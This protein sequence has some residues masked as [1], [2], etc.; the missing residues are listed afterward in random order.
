MPGSENST[1]SPEKVKLLSN[2]QKLINKTRNI[3]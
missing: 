3:E 2:Y 1:L